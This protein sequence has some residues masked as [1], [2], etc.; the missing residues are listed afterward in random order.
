MVALICAALGYI[1]GKVGAS[2]KSLKKG[3][4]NAPKIVSGKKRTA[5]CV[6]AAVF[7]L[8]F[9]GSTVFAAASAKA[10]GEKRATEAEEKSKKESEQPEESEPKTE[11]AEAESTG[12][13][14]SNEETEEPEEEPEPDW[15]SMDA[16]Y[17]LDKPNMDNGAIRALE[18]TE[19]DLHRFEEEYGKTYSYSS[20]NDMEIYRISHAKDEYAF[21][22]SILVNFGDRWYFAD[23]AEDL[24]Y[25]YSIDTD[26]VDLDDKVFAKA[27]T[28]MKDQYAEWEKEFRELK[29]ENNDYEQ[30]ARDNFLQE[31]LHNPQATIAWYELMSR[32]SVFT[33]NNDWIKKNLE[34]MHEVYKLDPKEEE[35]VGTA[36]FLTNS[37]DHKDDEQEEEHDYT[38]VELNEKMWEWACYGA[39]MF[40]LTDRTGF[41]NTTSKIRWGLDIDD[42]YPDL[43]KP[44]ILDQKKDQVSGYFDM[45]QVKVDGKVVVSYGVHCN[46]NGLAEFD[47]AVAK[48]TTTTTQKKTPDYALAAVYIEKATGAKI[49]PDFIYPERLKA[50]APYG[51]FTKEIAGYTLLSTPAE[52]QGF[53]SG[54][55]LVKVYYKKNTTTNDDP[56]GNPDPGPGSDPDPG[57]GPGPGPKPEGDKPKDDKQDPENDN[58]ND[59]GRGD[60]DNKGDGEAETQK[61]PAQDTEPADSEQS[62][63]GGSS[64]DSNN[65]G[66]TNHEGDSDSSEP[67]GKPSAVT[68]DK[69]NGD[70]E[71]SKPDSQKKDGE[72]GGGF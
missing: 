52:T 34:E 21:S 67:S 72:V 64:G 68:E 35:L 36:T 63:G 57:P 55:T 8:F 65:S 61:P 51:P 9:V 24:E 39:R 45:Y 41:K 3:K 2:G 69:G 12:D 14:S 47:I 40:E 16:D 18:M 20:S 13:E 23:N 49:A 66:E 15:E 60:S 5:F 32:H 17:L 50:G 43:T 29:P 59:Q 62:G 44:E 70:K 58:D 28:E 7:M 4:N 25:L 19:R 56:G 37:P 22:Q 71:T 6:L 27:R 26:D 46:D 1:C 31:L 54:D 38:H 30:Y 33:Q 11:P 10:Y 42:E 48:K 53:I